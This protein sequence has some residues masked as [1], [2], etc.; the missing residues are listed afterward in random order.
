MRYMWEEYWRWNIKVQ[1]S[2]ILL[3][4]CQGTALKSIH[5]LYFLFCFVHKT[6]PVAL[7]TFYCPLV[8]F[9]GWPLARDFRLYSLLS[10]Y[11]AFFF[12]AWKSEGIKIEGSLLM[13]E[14]IESCQKCR[15]NPT[16]SQRNHGARY[17]VPFSPECPHFEVWHRNVNSEYCWMLT[18]D[19]NSMNSQNKE[20]MPL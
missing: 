7:K 14:G 2:K 5:F 16:V 12:Q 11:R 20:T 17:L 3:P 15:N 6:G 18:F 4:V 19:R 9:R 13:Y 8:H 10:F 1:S